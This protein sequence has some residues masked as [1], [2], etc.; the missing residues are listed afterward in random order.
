[1]YIPGG[2]ERSDSSRFS[3]ST[4]EEE[5]VEE[6]LARFFDNPSYRATDPV[7]QQP[8]E[9]EED[10]EDTPPVLIP[11][12]I[13]PGPPPQTT[14]AIKRQRYLQRRR[15]RKRQNEWEGNQN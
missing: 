14:R 10:W 2:A 5:T 6:G 8:E 1:M 11:I 3:D 13:T 15:E 7:P 4:G 12:S 9:S